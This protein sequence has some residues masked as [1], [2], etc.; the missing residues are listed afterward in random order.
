[1]TALKNWFLQKPNPFRRKRKRAIILPVCAAYALTALAGCY[2]V[3]VVVT[4]VLRVIGELFDGIA[5]VGSVVA[6]VTMIF[7]VA[8][9]PLIMELVSLLSMGQLIPLFMR[10]FSLLSPP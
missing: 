3:A 8:V 1:M 6:L 2:A 9:F 4:A 10:V 5:A 7:V